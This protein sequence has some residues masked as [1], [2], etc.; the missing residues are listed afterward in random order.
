MMRLIG[1]TAD[2]ERM[3]RSIGGSLNIELEWRVGIDG[4]DARDIGVEWGISRR[5]EHE[6]DNGRA[7]RGRQ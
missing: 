3:V 1:G 2:E 5:G 6:T 4:T 7:V